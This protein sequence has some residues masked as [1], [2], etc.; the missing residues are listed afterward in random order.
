MNEFLLENLINIAIVANGGRRGCLIETAHMGYTDNY[1][2]LLKSYAECRNCIITY[3]KLS[4]PEFAR[5]I[6]SKESEKNN[7]AEI[8]SASDLGSLLGMVYLRPDF[9]DFMARRFIGRITAIITPRKVLNKR[10]KYLVNIPTTIEE[11]IE[12]ALYK[13]I[14]NWNQTIRVCLYTE[15]SKEKDMLTKNILRLWFIWNEIIRKQY[16]IL[17]RIGKLDIRLEHSISVDDGIRWRADH[18]ND[19]DYF[20]ANFKHYANDVWNFADAGVDVRLF[21]KSPKSDGSNLEKYTIAWREI[22]E[23]YL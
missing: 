9:D 20:L 11:K 10:L 18:L 23:G 7:I 17:G 4:M 2:Q 12:Y 8:T 5:Y 15:V 22:M 16:P 13:G 6:V 14:S 1:L 3:D 19:A 21:D